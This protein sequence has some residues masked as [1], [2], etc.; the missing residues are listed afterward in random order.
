[1]LARLPEK[2][3]TFPQLT[4]NCRGRDGWETVM[5]GL[6]LDTTTLGA[7]DD[8]FRG[9]GVGLEGLENHCQLGQP[10]SRKLGSRK[11]PR[12]RLT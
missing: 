9:E 3:R 5:G 1:M 4:Y 10:P 6:G 8:I 11:G 12:P 7:G 2:R